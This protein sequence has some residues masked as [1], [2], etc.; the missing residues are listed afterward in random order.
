MRVKVRYSFP[1]EECVGR[2]SNRKKSH[3]GTTAVF[4]TRARW[5]DG[6]YL[7][8]Y[9]RYTGIEIMTNLKR[10]HSNEGMRGFC[11]HGVGSKTISHFKEPMQMNNDNY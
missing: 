5:F 9:E 8:I 10:I 7:T 4:S 11:R 6:L 2:E 1:T 3:T